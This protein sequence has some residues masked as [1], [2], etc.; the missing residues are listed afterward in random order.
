MQPQ[1]DF[2]TQID[3]YKKNAVTE[4]N[5]SAQSEQEVKTNQV[6]AFKD[7]AST[8]QSMVSAVENTGQGSQKAFQGFGDLLSQ[9]KTSLDTLSAQESPDV[10]TPIVQAVARLETATI[11][12]IKQLTPNVKVNAPDVN[13]MAPKVDL[14][15]VKKALQEDI[16]QA[17]NQ[18][19]ANIP[20]PEVPEPIDW[21]P[22]MDIL[23]D[24]SKGVRMKPIQP[25][26][27][28]VTNPDGSLVGGSNV[29]VTNDGT[30]AKETGGN[31]DEI[32][33]DT[34]NLVG[35]KIDLDEIAIDT[36]NLA[37]I[38]AKT[39]NL[40]VTLSTRLKPADTLTKVA[41]VDTITN[42]V[43][44]TGTFW[45]TTQPTSEIT[46][47]MPKVYDYISANFSGAT[48]DVYTYKVG[49]SGGSTA[50]T[51][52]VN[53]TDSTKAVLSSVVRT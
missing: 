47:L 23:T 8:V 33:L 20:Q 6:Q 53:W 29:S 34:D 22:V 5:K 27:I 38:K 31:L 12:A 51:L 16:P 40:D 37:L 36:D 42:P 49:G 4:A 41:T 19:I 50:A 1:T 48:A 17:F 21:T 44:V 39:D 32:A 15:G 28:K 45:Q 30:F 2:Q 10:A 3:K 26:T 13:V 52:T 14:S 18:A 35:I 43:A 9:I 24:I 46:G 25:L 7:I 11:K